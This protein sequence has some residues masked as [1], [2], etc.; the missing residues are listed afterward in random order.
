[1]REREILRE[2]ERRER[3][4]RERM[5]TFYEI[6]GH[7]PPLRVKLGRI[8]NSRGDIKKEMLRDLPLYKLES[9]CQVKIIKRADRV[10]QAVRRSIAL[11]LV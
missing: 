8:D 7:R 9:D 11:F 4:E 3:R 5:S 6:K 1:M 2:R 10:A